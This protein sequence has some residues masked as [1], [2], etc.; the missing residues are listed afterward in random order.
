MWVTVIAQSIRF[1]I[2]YRANNNSQKL[3]RTN[4]SILF[5]GSFTFLFAAFGQMLGLFSAFNFIQRAGTD[6]VDSNVLAGGLKVTFIPAF[7]GL[8]LLL[9]SSII[10][11]VF[12][13]L[14]ITG[15]Q[16]M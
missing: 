5:I 2:L 3:L 7:Y 9:V 1:I 4:N 8:A 6:G 13:N 16:D 11:Y 15:Q 14:K 12:R 10:W